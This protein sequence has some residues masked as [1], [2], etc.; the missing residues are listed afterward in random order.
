MLASSENIENKGQARPISDS[1]RHVNVTKLVIYNDIIICHYKLRILV[2]MNMLY[3][4]EV[5][6]SSVIH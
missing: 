3:D 2:Y 5:I 6:E 1:E 4:E